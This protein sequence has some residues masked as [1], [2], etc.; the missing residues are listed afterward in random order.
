MA[1][2]FGVSFGP[3]RFEGRL[4]VLVVLHLCYRKIAYSS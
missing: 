3:D 2:V 1:V 4:I